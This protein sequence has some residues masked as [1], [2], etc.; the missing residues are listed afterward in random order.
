MASGLKILTRCDSTT[1]PRILYIVTRQ[2]YKLKKLIVEPDEKGTNLNVFITIN[3]EE[4]PYRL[5][6]L[7]QK[8]VSVFDVSVE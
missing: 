4:I 2:G 7:I 5:V 8:Q 6:R 3:S 1:V